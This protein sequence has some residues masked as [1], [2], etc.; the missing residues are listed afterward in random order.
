MKKY[1][2]PFMTIIIL[3]AAC[4]NQEPKASS[5]KKTCKT[6]TQTETKTPSNFPYPNLLA[7]NNQSYSLLVV[8]NQNEQTPIEKNEKVTSQVKNILSL[9]EREM[10]TNV[11]PKLEIQKEAAYILFS[12]TGIV[13]QSATIEDLIE[14]L[15]KNPIK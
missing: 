1:L 7:E 15:S 4:Q 5:S 10:V 13:H 8:G 12:Q 2:L 9:P 3:L 11:Y 6:I 14:Y